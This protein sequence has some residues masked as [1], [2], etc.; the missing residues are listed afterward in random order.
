MVGRQNRFM[1]R[2]GL[3]SVMLSSLIHILQRGFRLFGDAA[4]AGNIPP[5]IYIQNTILLFPFLLWL[6]GGLLY[7]ANETH[8]HI[9]L[10]ASLVLLSSSLSVVVGGGSKAELHLAFFAAIAV[11]A[12]YERIRLVLVSALIVAAI[13]AAGLALYPGWLY[14]S[15]EHGAGIWLLHTALL[16]VTVSAAVLQIRSKSKVQ[17]ALTST[18]N[19]ASGLVHYFAA[20]HSSFVDFEPKTNFVAQRDEA[21]LL[22][23]SSDAAVDG[24]DVQ[25]RQPVHQASN[26]ER[27][28]REFERQSA[29]PSHP[30]SR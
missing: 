30:S 26:L 12:H 19:A 4:A 15:T 24:R 28:M 17:K 20:A 29:N 1:L 6:A 8:R 22:P 25:A 18:E 23:G 7:R 5:P 14:E 2:L 11:I 9:P 13:Q 27:A 10:F 3:A 16:A 21:P